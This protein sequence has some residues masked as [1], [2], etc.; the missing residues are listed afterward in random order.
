MLLLL[1]AVEGREVRG[2]SMPVLG[3]RRTRKMMTVGMRRGGARGMGEW[4]VH[5][6]YTLAPL[7]APLASGHSSSSSRNSSSPK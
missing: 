1:L 2:P 4:V 3:M 7:A 6:E 5:L